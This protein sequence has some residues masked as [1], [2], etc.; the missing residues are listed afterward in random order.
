MQR[1]TGTFVVLKLC[2]DVRGGKKE[3]VLAWGFGY[4]ASG[5]L[6]KWMATTARS[7]VFFFSWCQSL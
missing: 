2:I 3:M 1:Q 7:R 6:V 5:N 4:H